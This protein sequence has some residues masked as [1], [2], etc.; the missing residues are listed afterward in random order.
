MTGTDDRPPE[1]DETA[2][3]ELAGR[4]FELARG[5]RC[6]DLLPYL[7]AGLP[8]NLA[9]DSGDTL[10]MLAAYH[11][12]INVVD[13]L[14]ARGADPDRTNDRGQ[15]PLAGAVFKGEDDVVR[16]LLAAGADPGAGT[17]TA[18]DTARMFGRVDL[19]ELLSAPR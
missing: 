6:A 19:V 11:G 15:S 16:A 5:G 1:P 9:N 13:A 4:L 3:S 7:D 17:P 2:L 8:I 18:L 14:L 12:R 10:L